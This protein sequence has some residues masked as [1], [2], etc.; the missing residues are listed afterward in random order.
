MLPADIQRLWSSSGGLWWPKAV[1]NHIMIVFFP[2][3]SS[4]LIKRAQFLAV[5]ANYTFLFTTDEDFAPAKAPPNKK[6]RASI[7]EYQRDKATK[8]EI[9]DSSGKARSERCMLSFIN[10]TL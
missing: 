10:L 7:N 6:A 4:V 2:S 9:T 5:I 1:L 3:L 8:S